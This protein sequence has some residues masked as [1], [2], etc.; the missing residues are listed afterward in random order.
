V[1]QIRYG[2][3][4][5][6][7][8]V[9]PELDNEKYQLIIRESMKK[10]ETAYDMLEICK[11]SAPRALCLNRQVIVLLS[12]R[13]ICD[14]NFLILQ[15]KTLLWLVQSLLNNQKAFQLLIDKV[16]DVF[17]L[18]E[19]SQN[20]DLVNE[21][22]FRDLVI[23]CCLNNVLDLLK[24]T[25]IKVSK[26]KAR[27]MFGTVDEYGVLKDGQVFIQP[28]P[29]P[30]INDKRISPVSAKPF[31]GRVAITKNP[32]HHPGDI[33]TFEAVDHPKLQHLKDVVVFPCQGHRPH[34]HEI[35]GSDLDGDE[36][37]VIWHED[38][39]PTT[40]NADPYDYDLQKEPE[41]QNRPITR[42]D[43]S[44]SVLT[45]A[46]QDCIG[47]LSNLHLAFVDKQGVDDS[48]C[49]QLA[50]FISQ[51]VDSPKTGKHPLTDAEINEISNKLNN[52]RPD[53]MENRN[54]RSYLSP[55]IL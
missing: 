55:Y 51:E 9:R 6:T 29:L 12:N 28:T 40:P 43:I 27:N 54:M 25:K 41:K 13:H 38:L 52:E 49:K 42:N 26:S 53:F 19:L 11:L 30:N 17:P 20:V 22:F 5:G 4:K 21:V 39:V 45:I 33:R 8:S 7:L 18:Q 15:N 23:G 50:G 35:S 24:R 1:M 46:E 16:L 3:C 37:A 14:S 48:F 34:P 2:G 36:Y 31:V 32:C 44:N 10:F 47:R